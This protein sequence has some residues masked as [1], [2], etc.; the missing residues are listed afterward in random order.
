MPN[1]MCWCAVCVD[2]FSMPWC[3]YSRRERFLFTFGYKVEVNPKKSDW[4]CKILCYRSWKLKFHCFERNRTK[5]KPSRFC[6]ES[7]AI[8]P[9][10]V[11]SC[12]TRASTQYSWNA[13]API[14]FELKHSSKQIDKQ[15]SKR[16]CVR[17]WYPSLY[18]A[19]CVCT[20][21]LYRHQIERLTSVL[22]LIRCNVVK[23]TRCIH[24]LWF[25]QSFF[26]HLII[27]PYIC[28]LLLLCTYMHTFATCV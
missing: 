20:R 11:F 15:P 27:L 10:I 12:H 24:T 17:I 25:V 21:P 18:L 7:G 23:M 9:T 3:N 6:K 8:W 13:H 28:R 1:F 4:K 19:A 2:I 26:I 22:M 14:T 16:T 5:Q